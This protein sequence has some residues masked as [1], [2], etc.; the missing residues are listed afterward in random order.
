M[1]NDA[2]VFFL[3]QRGRA[4]C[5]FIKVDKKVVQKFGKNLPEP[6][7]PFWV[8]KIFA[9]TPTTSPNEGPQIQI[10]RQ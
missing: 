6:P 4:A 2:A 3:E 10:G 7:P 8:P 1:G 5:H 9:S